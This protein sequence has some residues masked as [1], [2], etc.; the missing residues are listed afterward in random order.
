MYRAPETEGAPLD[1]GVMFPHERKL[2]QVIAHDGQP[3]VGDIQSNIFIATI[4]TM[5]HGCYSVQ[6]QQQKLLVEQLKREAAVT[7]ISVSQ[8]THCRCTS[9]ALSAL[10]PPY[11]A[12]VSQKFS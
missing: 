12:P 7:R 3:S 1:R 11:H 8:V 5:C 4:S 10:R 9:A 6:V 2:H